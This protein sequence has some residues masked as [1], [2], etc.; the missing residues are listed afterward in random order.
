MTIHFSHEN[1]KQ[2]YRVLRFKI[3][4][5]YT[6][7]EMMILIMISILMKYFGQLEITHQIELLI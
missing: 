1:S 4:I 2:Q 7:Y 6:I 5:K 3:I